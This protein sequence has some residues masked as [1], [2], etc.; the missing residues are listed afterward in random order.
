MCQTRRPRTSSFKWLSGNVSLLTLDLW[1]CGTFAKGLKCGLDWEQDRLDLKS[2]AFGSLT[3]SPSIETATATP[4]TLE[5]S[6]A[7]AGVN[8][9]M[10]CALSQLKDPLWSTQCRP[11]P[12][13]CPFIV[14]NPALSPYSARLPTSSCHFTV[15]VHRE[16]PRPTLPRCLFGVNNL[17]LP[18]YGAHSALTTSLCH[19][20][21][22]AYC[23]SRYLFRSYYRRLS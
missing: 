11:V 16:C 5:S 4:P 22:P 2:P 20:A 9:D 23:Q 21:V 18:F 14:N 8:A 13:R 3:S 7:S 6:H 17:P 10:R 12:P 15:P 19:F 1:L